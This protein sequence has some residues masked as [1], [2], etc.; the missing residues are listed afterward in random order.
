MSIASV[1]KKRATIAVDNIIEDMM[2]R[3]QFADPWEATDEDTKIE[4][5]DTWR[6]IITEEVGLGLKSLVAK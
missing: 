4:V 3:P 2:T 5:R 1:A 6:A